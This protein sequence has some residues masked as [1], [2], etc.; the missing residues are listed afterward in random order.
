M[1]ISY[2]FAGFVDRIPV[3]STIIIP[4]TYIAMNINVPQ[5]KA[6]PIFTSN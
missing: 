1:C 5:P 4:T 2:P 3:N 6:A